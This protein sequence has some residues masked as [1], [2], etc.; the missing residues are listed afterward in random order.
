MQSTS[1]NLGELSRISVGN[2]PKLVVD[3]SGKGAMPRPF[4]SPPSFPLNGAN[5]SPNQ[6]RMVM[7]PTTSFQQVML[8]ANSPS[9][10]LPPFTTKI[11]ELPKNPKEFIATLLQLKTDLQEER[12]NVELKGMS[13][14]TLT[15]CWKFTH[16]LS[17]LSRCGNNEAAEATRYNKRRSSK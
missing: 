11:S 8:G 9:P 15:Y 13:Y 4:L 10:S 2:A 17:L 14:L 12:H 3:T 16:S 7:P 1:V 6:R 5:N